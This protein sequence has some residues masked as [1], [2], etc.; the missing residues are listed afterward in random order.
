[1]GD[2]QQESAVARL[3]EMAKEAEGGDHRRC[4]NGEV[5]LYLPYHRAL[6]P[7]HIYSESGIA[8]AKISGCCEY[9]FDRYFQPGWTDPVTGE[10]GLTPKEN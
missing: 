10:P 5:M 4:V 3:Q 9:H 7:G 8:E 6:V 2:A 1:M